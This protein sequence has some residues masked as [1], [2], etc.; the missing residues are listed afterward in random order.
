M[1]SDLNLVSKKLTL[2]KRIVGEKKETWISSEYT[3]LATRSKFLVDFKMDW[4]FNFAP[5]EWKLTKLFGCDDFETSLEDQVE[6][7]ILT[8]DGQFDRL[9]LLC[10]R[11]DLL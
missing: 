2:R 6:E 8:V 10:K 9:S 4:S 3:K 5:V 1:L 7:C 11:I